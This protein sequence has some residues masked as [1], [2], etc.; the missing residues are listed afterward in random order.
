MSPHSVYSAFNSVSGCSYCHS[1]SHTAHQVSNL[2]TTVSESVDTHMQLQPFPPGIADVTEKTWSDVAGWGLQLQAFTYAHTHKRAHT[3]SHCAGLEQMDKV[4]RMWPEEWC[5]TGTAVL[6][7]LHSRYT[8]SVT[9]HWQRGKVSERD[10]SATQPRP[11]MQT[12]K[13]IWRKKTYC[14]FQRNK[15]RSITNGEAKRCI[16]SSQASQSTCCGKNHLYLILIF[17]YTL[18]TG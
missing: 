12:L 14:I 16:P 17:S 10:T 4:G 9:V 18:E 5:M 1:L 8:S 6:S 13:G 11:V 7:S 15:W 2:D 3:H